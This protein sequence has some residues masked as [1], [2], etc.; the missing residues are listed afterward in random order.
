VDEG[1][2]VTFEKVMDFVN[3]EKI[4]ETLLAH[5]APSDNIFPPPE[6]SRLVVSSLPLVFAL[7][8]VLY[9]VCYL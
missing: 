5:E 6:C 4:G 1:V 2:L 9:A 8:L 3:R 7:G